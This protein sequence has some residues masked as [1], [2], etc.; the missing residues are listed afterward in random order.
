V[1][2]RSAGYMDGCRDGGEGDLYQCD[3]QGGSAVLYCQLDEFAAQEVTEI[4]WNGAII[5]PKTMILI[6]AQAGNRGA[7]YP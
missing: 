5:P 2:P 3:H 7:V 6:N 1:V 4:N